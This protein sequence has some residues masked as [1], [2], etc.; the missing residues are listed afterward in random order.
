MI[1]ITPSAANLIRA[2]LLQH[3]LRGDL[4][5]KYWKH[6]SPSTEPSSNY[7][8]YLGSMNRFR[9]VQGEK[10]ETREL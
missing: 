3:D 10:E 4:L 6:H 8:T 5:I 9:R 1:T 7:R 2:F